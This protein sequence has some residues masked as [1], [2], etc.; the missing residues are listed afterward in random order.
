MDGVLRRW[1]VGT[2]L[3]PRFQEQ[4]WRRIERVEAT[5]EVAPQAAWLRFLEFVLPRPKV[6][7]V[8]L[9]VLLAS[10]VT[11]GSW[12]AQRQNARIVSS[13]GSRYLQSVDPYLAVPPQ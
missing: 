11:A 3:P 10:G 4:V 8:Y 7:G 6:A 13:L 1:V 2:P 12:A 9:A 5:P